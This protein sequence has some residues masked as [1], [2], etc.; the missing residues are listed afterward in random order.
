MPN[1]IFG[2]VMFGQKNLYKYIGKKIIAILSYN[3]NYSGTS[4]TICYVFPRFYQDDNN[5]WQLISVEDFLDYGSIAVHLI[6]KQD[7]ENFV[8]EKGSLVTIKINKG[9]TDEHLFPQ[10]K[11][12]KYSYHMGFSSRYGKDKSQI[13]IEAFSERNKFYQL[14]SANRPYHELSRLKLFQHEGPIFTSEILVYCDGSYY[15]PFSYEKKQDSYI[16]ITIKEESSLYKYVQKYDKYSIMDEQYDICDSNNNTLYSLVSVKYVD[17]IQPNAKLVDWLSD[18]GLIKAFTEVISSCRS[19]DQFLSEFGDFLQI[20][21]SN[22]TADRYKRLQSIMD[23]ALNSKEFVRSSMEYILGNSDLKEL[24]INNLP[25]DGDYIQS[26]IS[27]RKIQNDNNELKEEND[28]LIKENSLL[29]ERIGENV[30][31]KNTSELEKIIEKLQSE[32]KSMIEL[33]GEVSYLE[34]RKEILENNR[35]ELIKEC[36]QYEGKLNII[37]TS[38]TNSVE[39][40]KNEANIIAKQIDTKLL[41]NVLDAISS[42]QSNIC[43]SQVN[44]DILVDLSAEEIIERVRNYFYD[45]NRNISYNDIVNYLIC[46]SQ[47]FITTFAGEPGTGKTSLCS[48]LSNALGLSREDEYNRYTEIS[49]ERGWNSVKDFIGYYNPLT[50]KVEQSN[51]DAFNTL[52][53]INKELDINEEYAPYIMLL[54]EANLSPIE[55]YWANFLRICDRNSV[56]SRKLNLG[57]IINYNIPNHLRFL[58]T[59]NFDHTTEELSPRFLDRSWI[60]TLKPSFNITES[61]IN[62]RKQDNIVSYSSLIK[63]FCDDTSEIEKSDIYFQ[64]N[65]KWKKIQNIFNECNKPIMPRNLIMVNN[66]IKIACKYMEQQGNNRY[67]PLDFAI[68]QKIL[69][70]INGNGDVYKRLVDMLIDETSELTLT[71]EH[72]ERIKH[73]AEQNMDFYQFFAR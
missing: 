13:W 51:A 71:N 28:K 8:K 67:V 61:N 39:E 70:L 37:K 49:V 40:L 42:Q 57:G 22:I 16:N 52:E 23:R 36:E 47:G 31:E 59:V 17:D 68:S 24:F 21:A 20:S 27:Y 1:G 4:N 12:G 33:Y 43:L 72:L 44:K 64:N 19:S 46:I 38:I 48:L 58:A 62:V 26:N 14:I 18:S 29:K 7:A 11:N 2:E 50:N 66:Y 54:D 41:N 65:E 34:E 69:P 45:V 15:G 35:L 60:I 10:E 6:E 9:N 25:D 3:E 55:H 53:V 63:A 56:T 73:M 32:N 30:P 5:Q